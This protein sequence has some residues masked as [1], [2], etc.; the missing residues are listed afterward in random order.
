M[1]IILTE[2]EYLKLKHQSD[3]D[4]KTYVKRVDVSIAL[5]EMVKEMLKLKN[6]YDPMDFRPVPRN[7]ENDW[8]HL[9]QIFW[10]NIENK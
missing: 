10:E 7:V 4:K 1:Q 6:V 2:D 3:E 8:K 9:A 5:E